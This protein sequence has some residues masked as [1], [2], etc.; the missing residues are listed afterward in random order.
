MPR[1]FHERFR[2][3]LL[4][5]GQH[6]HLV[7]TTTIRG[8][9]HTFHLYNLH[10]HSVYLRRRREEEEEEEDLVQILHLRPTLEEE[11]RGEEVLEEELRG[12]EGWDRV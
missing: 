1:I 7:R 5:Q 8:T 10:D 6:D 11:E 9:T 4:L 3:L 2:F 12:E